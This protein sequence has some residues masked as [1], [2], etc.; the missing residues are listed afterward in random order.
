[1]GK[2]FTQEIDQL[3]ATCEW[4]F[5][6]EIKELQRLMQRW[7]DGPLIVVG[8]GG[9]YSAAFA[10]ASFHRSKYGQPSFASTTLGLADFAATLKHCRI[11]LL[12]AEGKNNDILNAAK[13]ARSADIPCAAVSLSTNN[14][15]TQF[16]KSDSSMYSFVFSMNWEKDGYLATNTLCATVLLAARVYFDT[17]YNNIAHLVSQEN[18]LLVRNSFQNHPTLEK[19]H[20]QGVIL[21]HGPASALFALDL[22]SKLAEAALAS[23]EVVDFRQFAHGRH[24]QLTLEADKIPVVVAAFTGDE[25]AL[26]K[27]TLSLFPPAVMYIEIPIQGITVADHFL[28]S[29]FYAL[30][31][32]EAI[33]HNIN[34]DPGQPHVP[35]FGRKIY[36]LN[37]MAY[38]TTL[39]QSSLLETAIRRKTNGIKVSGSDHTLLLSAATAYQERLANSRVKALVCDFDGTLCHVHQRFSGMNPEVTRSLIALLDKGSHL[40]IATGRGQEVIAKIRE[41]IPS[42]LWPQIWIG[43]YSGALIMRLDADIPKP[44][45]NP[46]LDAALTWLKSSSLRYAIIDE[47]K[48]KFRGGQLSLRVEDHVTANRIAAALAAW[49]IDTN[50]VGWRVFSSG[51]S[52][53]LLD[54]K[55]SKINVITHLSTE[56]R[57]DPITQILR[58]GDA[59]E[60]GGNDFELLRDSLSL[61]ADRVSDSLTCCWN[62]AP[63]G[64]RQAAATQ[65][66]LQAMTHAQNGIRIALPNNQE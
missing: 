53:D 24:L 15:L 17:K 28:S 27:A 29:L 57:I 51:H 18:F 44:A 63:T 41:M 37:S 25:E 62:F 61:S 1:M 3:S 38:Q 54:E 6:Q 33:A 48:C 52:V 23:C 43:L 22:E 60:A 46:T 21:L 35:E 16:A 14:P 5:L 39:P 36:A 42:A 31:A 9:S 30:L 55:T 34:V 59:G 7:T 58:I 19:A 56:L 65:F 8:S 64:V 45:P 40:G 50:H 12:S 2:P 49:I 66:Y 32:T 4:V 13:L 10:W 47:G 20:S 11:L 26:A